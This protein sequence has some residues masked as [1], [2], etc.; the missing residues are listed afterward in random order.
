MRWTDHL[1][2]VP[3]VLPLVAGAAMLL[4]DEQRR[5]LKFAISLVSTLGLLAAAIV[6]MRLADGRLEGWSGSIGVYLAANWPVPFGIALAVDRLSALLLALCAVLALASL[7]FS[8]ARW[9]RAGVHFHALFQFL[10]MGVNGTFLTADL[11][12]LFVFFEVMLAA[13]YGLALHGSGAAR[14]AAGMHYVAVNLVA[15]SLFL[16]GV[17]ML[18]GVTG[19]LNMA[20]LARVIA[21]VSPHDRMLLEAGAA[22]L[23]IAFLV[24]SAMWPLAFWLPATYAAASAP[25]AAVFAIMTKVGIYVI[26]RLWLLLF[27]GAEAGAS[28]GF[29]RDLL[30][31]GGMAT[32][33]FATI[34]M[35]ASHDLRRLAAY[36]IIMSSGALLAAIGFGETAVVAGALFYLLSSTLSAGALFLLIELIERTRTAASSVLAVTLEAFEAQGALHAGAGEEAPEDSGVVIPAAMAFLGLSFV[37]SA[38]LVAGLPPLS[39]FIGKFALLA[40]M[41]QPAG[42]QAGGGVQPAA[43]IM[44][45]LL[46]A[47]G[48]AGAVALM[49]IGIRTFWVPTRPRVPRLRV[50]EAMPVAALLLLCLV[51]TVQAGPVMRYL[52]SAAGALARRDDYVRAVMG[53]PTVPSARDRAR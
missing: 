23:G 12:N 9:N 36:S 46:L 14:V 41:L 53:A 13:S 49:R 37:T 44:L 6:L 5:G 42:G 48:L 25:V 8:H 2:L 43:W 32:L 29:G 52:D 16:L 11:F 18:Y 21:H 34:G 50:I 26:L 15:S 4:V 31:Y 45:A 35:L 33:A 38:L 28:S 27:A 1:I 7:V 47:S 10:L 17:S 20:D 19:T 51:I 24:K 3:V 22:L 39:G 30:L 40:A